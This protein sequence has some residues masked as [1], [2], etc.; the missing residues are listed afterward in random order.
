MKNLLFLISTVF[1]L[2]F[3]TT[4][5]SQSIQQNE[6]MIPKRLTSVNPGET[7][8]L[9]GDSHAQGLRHRLKENA[10]SAGYKFSSHAIEGTMTKQWI[11]WLKKDIETNSPGLIIISLGTNDSVANEAWLDRNASCYEEIL[12]IASTSMTEVVW[13]GMPTYKTKRLK[14][15]RKV[16]D[17]IAATHVSM[18]DSTVVPI[19]LTE[20]GIHATASGY[21]TWSDAIWNWLAE[22]H[23]VLPK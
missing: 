11:K 6:D 23:Y 21:S 1:T 7:V 12:K 13:I 19:R 10:K 20:D 14:N 18:F 3:S 9:V 22:E 15:V 17:L 8:L 16:S 4:C 2:T 5:F